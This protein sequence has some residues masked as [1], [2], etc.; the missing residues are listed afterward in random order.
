MVYIPMVQCKDGEA[1]AYLQSYGML[2]KLGYFYGGMIE[3]I[4]LLENIDNKYWWWVLI[5]LDNFSPEVRRNHQDEIGKIL[6]GYD[7]G[8]PWN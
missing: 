3:R 8:D 5:T 7:E 4:E 2:R 1:E 6:D